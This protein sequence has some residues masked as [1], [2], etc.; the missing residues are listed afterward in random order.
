MGCAH[1][2]G[3]SQAVWG[4]VSRGSHRSPKRCILCPGGLQLS[5]GRKASKRSLGVGSWAEAA[6]RKVGRAAR[7]ICNPGAR[8]G[9]TRG[10]SELGALGGILFHNLCLPSHPLQLILQHI[11]YGASCFRRRVL[12]AFLISC[13]A[14]HLN[15]LGFEHLS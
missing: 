14:L 3:E 8:T 11:L 10:N 9:S 5:S 12:Y 6:V 1:V 15:N 2:R 13:H 4:C 7:R